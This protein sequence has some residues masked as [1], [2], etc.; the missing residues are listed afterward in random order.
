V[1]AVNTISKLVLVV[2]CVYVFLVFPVS[3]DA[4]TIKVRQDG[5]GDYTT[6]SDAVAVADSLDTIDVGPGIY[7][8][9]IFVYVSLTII[10]QY[11][12][13]ETILDGENERRVIWFIGALEAG[14]EGFTIQN[15]Y[16][17]NN[18]SGLRAQSGA[19]VTVRKCVFQSNYAEFTGAGALAHGE[20]TH[21]IMEDCEFA[22]NH[23]SKGSAGQSILGSQLDAIN[24]TFNRN[25]ALQQSAALQCNN[26]TMNVTHCIFHRNNSEDLSGAIYYYLSS[27]HVY[28]N[29]F[30][31]NSSPGDT[32]IHPDE[33]AS[34]V[35][36]LSPNVRVSRNIFSEDKWGFG[37]MIYQC[38]IIHSCNI[39]WS[40]HLGSIWGDSLAA[41]EIEADPLF[42]NP[43]NP[44]TNYFAIDHDSPAAAPNS[45]CSQFIGAH[46]PACGETVPVTVTL[47]NFVF[48]L[49]GN[50]PNPFNPTT[51]I[52]YSIEEAGHVLLQIYDVRGKLVDTLVDDIRPEGSFTAVWDAATLNGLPAASGVYFA[53]LESGGNL[54]TQKMMLLK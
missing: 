26:G 30:H 20:G 31:R 18:G 53:R 36:H 48:G 45:P 24:C 52:P 3:P 8:E 12:A 34:V 17:G 43:G 1:P 21:L 16:C 32:L 25:T 2:T 28:N 38:V 9:E 44:S 23:A 41:D 10:S 47:P 42:C 14:L 7:K 22:R 4:A 50:I 5:S 19:V 46:G 6:I 37:L 54:S 11:G 13:E 29:T 27:G 33:G 39:F 40:N 15:G 49:K 51:R 35:V